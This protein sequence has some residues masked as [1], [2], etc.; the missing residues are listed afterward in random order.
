MKKNGQKN[1]D[2]ILSFKLEVNFTLIL[3]QNVYTVYV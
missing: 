1:T 3:N 2:N